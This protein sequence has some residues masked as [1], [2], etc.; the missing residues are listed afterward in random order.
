[1]KFINTENRITA[2][3]DEGK[4]LAWVDF[5]ALDE[6]V[7]EVKS[8]FV[9]ESMRGQGLA[10]RL[11]RELAEYLLQSGKRAVPTCA[12]AVKWFAEHGEYS[13]LAAKKHD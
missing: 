6:G 8:T 11:M 7:V 4:A 1:M 9:D 2:Y 3:S 13:A 10:S 5:P 12:Y